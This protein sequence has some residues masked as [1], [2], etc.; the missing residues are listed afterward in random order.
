MFLRQFYIH[1][2]VIPDTCSWAQMLESA[3][4]RVQHSP[5]CRSRPWVPNLFR[6]LESTFQ[7]FK[8]AQVKAEMAECTLCEGACVSLPVQYSVSCA[9]RQTWASNTLPRLD[10]PS[11]DLIGVLLKLSNA[12]GV[13]CNAKRRPDRISILRLSD[14]F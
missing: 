13:S 8:S 5:C 6:A 7:S 14:R 9:C 3:G 12:V 4:S 11:D 1:S 10:S 2:P